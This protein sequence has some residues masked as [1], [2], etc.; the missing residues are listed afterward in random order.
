MSNVLLKTRS[1]SSNFSSS[2]TVIV[3]D[4]LRQKLFQRDRKSVE[5]GM[6]DGLPLKASALTQEADDQYIP[7]KLKGTST[8]VDL[9]LNINP[10]GEEVLMYLTSVDLSKLGRKVKQERKRGAIDSVYIR[11]QVRLLQDFA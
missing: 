3:Y 2:G 8:R 1:S 7:V 9:L 6:N 11:G 5:A 10:K 4:P